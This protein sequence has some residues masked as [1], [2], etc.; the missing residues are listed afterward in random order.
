MKNRQVLVPFILITLSVFIFGLALQMTVP[1][2]S[3]YLKTLQFPVQYLGMASLVLSLSALVFRPVSAIFNRKFGSIMTGII[4]GTIY[5]IAYLLFLN[6]ANPWI[7][8]LT[9]ILQGV[10]IGLFTTTMGTIISQILPDQDMLKGMNIFSM[11]NAATGAL[12]PYVGML[13]IASGNFNNLFLTAAILA[14]VGLLLLMVM[15]AKVKLPQPMHHQLTQSSTPLHKS[16][17]IF[18]SIMASILM[19]FQAALISYLAIYGQEVGIP[20]VGFFF[21]YSFVGLILSRFFV[22]ALLKRLPL[23]NILI[24]FGFAYGLVNLAFVIS[25]TELSWTFIAVAH[26][27]IFNVISV[28][29]NTMA[30][31][32]AAYADK[33][34]ANALYFAS[35]DLGF[36]SGGLMGGLIAKSLGT[37]YIFIISAGLGLIYL[38]SGAFYVYQKK[39][40]F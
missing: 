38:W 33:A 5:L 36:F 9:R 26:G 15:L 18:P 10:G 35:V 40:K 23:Y 6:N 28:I 20:N 31:K 25:P 22:S 19:V 32:N 13:L 7:V 27:F 29:Y 30:V 11:F 16:T 17:A 21:L 1:T 8:V 37:S 3:V 4:G 14:G 34:N 2:L 12:G 39:I 24:I